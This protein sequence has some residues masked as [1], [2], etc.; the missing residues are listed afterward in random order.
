MRVR[1]YPLTQQI[2]EKLHA[3]TRPY[4][5]GRQCTRV[6]DLAGVLLI[7]SDAVLDAVLLGEAIRV[8]FEVRATHA[9]PPAL[10]APP[11]RWASAFRRLNAELGL[12][13]ADLDQATDASR[14]F[15]DPIL[16]GQVVGAWDPA[17]WTWVMGQAP[18]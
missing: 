1:A 11:G 16:R 8:T 7:A 12:G 14:R 4:A 6:R 2:A 13:W 9:V 10:P 18:S 3:Y 15:L 17:R 5:R